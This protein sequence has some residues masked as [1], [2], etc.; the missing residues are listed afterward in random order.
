[1]LA[2]IS[3]PSRFVVL[4]EHEAQEKPIDTLPWASKLCS[5]GLPPACQHRARQSFT[6][7]RDFVINLLS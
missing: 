2:T 4:R 3:A 7:C 5:G 1:M 6:M